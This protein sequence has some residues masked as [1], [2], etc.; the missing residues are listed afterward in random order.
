M[1]EVP[2]YTADPEEQVREQVREQVE[3]A[4]AAYHDMLD[5]FV[6]SRARTAAAEAGEVRPRLIARPCK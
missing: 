2:F 1:A 3:A 6:S 5:T 4:V